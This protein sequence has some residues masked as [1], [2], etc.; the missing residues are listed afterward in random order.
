MN[1]I[2][3]VDWAHE[4]LPE[5]GQTYVDGGTVNV[6]VDTP[7]GPSGWP[8]LAVSGSSAGALLDWLITYNAGDLAD[9]LDLLK[10]AVPVAGE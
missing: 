1:V 5:L 3:K 7:V 8:V 2:V 10:T 4:R 9:S 6:A